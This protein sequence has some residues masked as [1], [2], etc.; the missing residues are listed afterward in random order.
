MPQQHRSSENIVSRRLF[1]Q[2]SLTLSAAVLLVACA[3]P[4]STTGSAG[5]TQ[6][7][8]QATTG[9]QSTTFNFVLALQ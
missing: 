7:S 6:A 8:P 3:G 2:Q 9:A 4:G 5:K 1:L